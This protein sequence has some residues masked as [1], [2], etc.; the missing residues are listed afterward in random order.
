MSDQSPQKSTNRAV[1]YTAL[2]GALVGALFARPIIRPWLDKHPSAFSFATGWPMLASFVPWIAFTI[3]WEIAAKDSA[4]VLKAESHFSR[5]IHVVLANAAL[6][7]IFFPIRGLNQHFLPDLL[8]LKL[9]GIALELAG[10]ALAIWARRILGRN[11]SGE[12]TIKEDHQLVR[13]GPYGTIRH[14][15]YTALLTM[16][17]GTAI[18]SG[19]MHALIG[20][21]IG[22][23]AY[24]RKARMEETNLGNAFGEKYTAYREDTWALIP[25]VY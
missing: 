1:R 10:I 14:P 3:Y 18:V 8:V 25:R 12:I 11:W 23:L 4:P 22:T 24:L 2:I 19:Q 17:L 21:A 13:G 20:L 9:G 5:G 6:L 16:Y 7:F 15:I